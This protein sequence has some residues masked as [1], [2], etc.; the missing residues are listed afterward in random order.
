MSLG[1][2]TN[3]GLSI[4]RRCRVPSGMGFLRIQDLARVTLYDVE[5]ELKA[6]RLAVSFF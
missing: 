6:V 1:R 2:T 4:E 3:Q 5:L